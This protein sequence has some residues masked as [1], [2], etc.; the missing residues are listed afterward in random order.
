M[1]GL[2]FIL[3]RHLELDGSGSLQHKYALK[4]IS[5][6]DAVVM[7]QEL[8]GPGKRGLFLTAYRCKEC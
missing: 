5:F 4:K 8:T 6:T 2:H 1:Y 3:Q 7:K